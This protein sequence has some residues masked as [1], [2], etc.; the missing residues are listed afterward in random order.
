ML[1]PIIQ[2]FNEPVTLEEARLQCHID[3]D[4]TAD[5]DRLIAYIAAARGM[6]EHETGQCFLPQ[7]WE[8]YLDAWPADGKIELP[9]IPVRSIAS[10]KYTNAAGTLTT[11]DA[12]AYRLDTR[13]V[14]AVLLPAYGSAWPTDVRSDDGGVIVITYVCGLAASGYELASIAPGIR[15]WM[16]VQVATAYRNREAFVVGKSVAELPGNYVNALLYPYRAYV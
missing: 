14:R 7:T 9:Q 8:L 5:D 13:A 15:E 11:V 16:L 2:P 12:G 4:D 3:P 6:A 1:R 10:V